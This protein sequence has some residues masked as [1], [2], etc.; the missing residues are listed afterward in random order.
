MDNFDITE[1]EDIDDLGVE[2]A[3]GAFT[4]P[5]VTQEDI[6]EAIQACLKI[7]PLITPSKS[8]VNSVFAISKSLFLDGKKYVIIEAPTGSGKTII[9]FMTYF[10]TQYLYKKK[11][12]EEINIDPR[13][14]PAGQLSYFLTS[15][16]M[17][18]EQIDA[19]LDRF[20]FRD[21]IH[22]LK[23][24]SNYDCTLETAKLTKPYRIDMK[25]KEINRIS[26]SERPCKGR[27][28]KEREESL[29][30]GE[31]Q[32]TCPYQLNR[33]YAAESSNTVLNYAYFLNVMRSAFKPF[34]S[35][36]LITVADEAHLIPDIVCNIFNFE[37]NQF[38]LNQVHKILQELEMN[39]GESETL[40]ITKSAVMESF[41]HFKQ[42]LKSPS[43]LLEYFENLSLISPKLTIL[44][45]RED[46]ATYR[47]EIMKNHERI[48]ELLLNRES[49]RIL[50]EQ[51]PH[52][53]YFESV[54]IAHDKV[55]DSKV[56]KHIIRDLDESAMVE[57]HFLQ[58]LNKGI[59]MSATLG[60]I[61]QYAKMMGMKEDEYSALRLP[62]LFD[63]EKS[64]VYLCNSVWLNYANFEKNIDKAL[65]DTLKICL[66]YHPK[67]KGII[68]TSTFKI[69]NLL[70]DKVNMGLV[71]DKT[72]FLFYSNAEE[73]EKMVELMKQSTKPYII[74]GPSLYEGLDLKDDQGR[75]NI[76]MKVP[77]AGMD[78]YTKKKIDRFPF[79]YERNTL[80]KI[81]Q[82]IGRTNRH[83][84]D[85]SKVYLIDACFEKIIHNTSKSISDR[86]KYKK[87]I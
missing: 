58:K 5:G 61:D 67:E 55:T 72:R 57:R 59:F 45:N 84:N 24:V 1:V 20:D 56:Y 60:D 50:V 16:K 73:K 9:G 19:D 17:L 82:A 51:R 80:E 83:T 14:V 3:K 87:I 7:S 34:F 4:I 85:Y 42:P 66:E 40:D 46:L 27:S 43:T 64:P 35:E 33:Q 86:V 10:V 15:S 65:M 41:K 76:L 77:Y 11:L 12:C 29:E 54:L 71:P 49:F 69:C 13:P 18:Q 21:Y 74:V 37:F 53:I 31:C 70:K 8:L 47:K 22:M 26:Y 32:I 79:W 78:D 48:D 28:K 36:R 44:A 25:G 38:V 62:S 6:I 23:G 63:F 75:F 52:D 30:F 68:H 81:G 2:V 39:F